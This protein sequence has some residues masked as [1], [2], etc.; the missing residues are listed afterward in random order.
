LLVSPPRERPSPRSS[1]PLWRPCVDG[2]ERPWSRSRPASPPPPGSARTTGCE[3]AVGGPAGETSVGGLP[4]AEPLGQL[5]PGQSGAEL[6]HDA[7]EDLA[8]IP[9]PATSPAHR[10]QQR[11]DHRPRG[12][13]NLPIPHHRTNDP[14]IGKA[15]P[16]RTHPRECPYQHMRLAEIVR[17][18]CAVGL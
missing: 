14:M 12:V 13:R 10:R 6:E 5:S 7:L 11:F 3:G 4:R 16:N 1:S 15:P 17:D 9:P 2:R 18:R 8:V